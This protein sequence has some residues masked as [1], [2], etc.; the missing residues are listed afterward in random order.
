MSGTISDPETAPESKGA[1]TRR[2]ILDAAIEHFAAVGLDG[3]SVPEI[4]RQVGISHS[5]L[6]QHFGRKEELFRAAVDRDLTAMVEEAVP[7][8]KPLEADPRGMGSISSRLLDAT[9]AHPLARRVLGNLD[10]EQADLLRDLPALIA[11]ESRMEEAVG[12]GQAAGAL[13]ADIAPALV[14]KGLV[15]L[16]IAMLSAGVRLEGAD[17]PRAAAAVDLMEHL[18]A[19]EGENAGRG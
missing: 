12:E 19:P 11:L 4:A 3:G 5:A 13:R 9:S 18:L 16:S 7:P 17:F 8:G 15:T 14:A 1:R 10:R 2:R 6:Y